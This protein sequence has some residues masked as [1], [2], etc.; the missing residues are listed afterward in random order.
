MAAWRL[1][2]LGGL[3]VI[4]ADDETITHFESRKTAALLAYLALHPERAHPREELAALIWPDAEFEASRN[5]LKQSLA[6]LRKLLGSDVFTADRFSV[7]VVPGVMET[8][9][10]Q[11]ERLV[12]AGR[13]R[14]AAGLWRGELLPGFYDEVLLT[15]R[16]R[17]NALHMKFCS[18][19]ASPLTRLVRLPSPPTRFVGRVAEKAQLAMLLQSERWITVIGPGG[20]GKTRLATEVAR[21]WE[22]GDSAFVALA[23]LERV[24]QVSG[25]IAS[26]LE[27]TLPASKPPLE[28]LFGTLLGRP[29]LLVLDNA[30]HLPVEVLAELC[31]TLLTRLPELRLLVTSRQALCGVGEIRVVLEPL[32]LTEDAPAL[33]L[34]RAQ[35]VRPEFPASEALVHLCALLEGMPLAI[36]L[37][38][39]WAAGLTAAQMQ[40]R[41]E[42]GEF[43]RLLSRRGVGGEEHHFS[44]EAIFHSSYERLTPSQQRLLCGL[45]VFRGGWTLDAAEAVCPT[46]DTLGDLL[47]LCEASLIAPRGAERFAMLESL[48]RFASAL[49]EP[50]DTTALRQRHHAWCLGFAESRNPERDYLVRCDLEL[51]NLRH[52]LEAEH[53]A[54]LL[55]RLLPFMN[56][57]GL[58]AE[59]VVWLERALGESNLSPLLRAELLCQLGA[60]LLVQR[61][62]HT[63]EPLIHE[64][65]ALARAEKSPRVEAMALYQLGRFAEFQQ[66]RA[67]AWDYHQRAL[68]L[69]RGLDDPEALARSCN[70]LSDL[71]V[72]QG[73]LAEALPLLSEAETLARAA[74]REW[75]LGDILYNRAFLAMMSG[76]PSAA[77]I[78][79]SECQA[80]ARALNLRMLLA[81][82]TQSLGCT[83]MEL[84]ETRRAQ[85]ELSEAARLFHALRSKNG[86]SYPLWNLA[87]LYQDSEE[88]DRA[89]VLLAASVR[90]GEELGQ[91]LNPDDQKFVDTLRAGASKTLGV[92]LAE[93]FWQQGRGLPL[94]ELLHRLEN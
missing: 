4:G 38:A 23:P 85:T 71:A 63:A 66:E 61:N 76:D 16:E 79:L 64:A 24:E 60:N 69:R 75:L 39:A 73:R 53:D 33:F 12:R 11:W 81:R 36:E 8:D 90:L 7:R 35:R 19:E 58:I 6:S 21:A 54:S 28:A 43:A 80:L 56:A 84:G 82:A 87:R 30:E 55:L 2:L 46:A 10:A 65:L 49:L 68:E 88:W 91:P 59:Q 42:H 37:C 78:V 25:A 92:V 13:T 20:M 83:A 14:E 62:Q 86:V 27:L 45:T 3:R 34:D 48:R 51:D 74:G 94:E 93:H 47:C 57:R 22:E 26:V 17:L 32:N 15:E 72:Q 40:A 29:T 52:A 77:L 44:V 89:V 70:I 5:R 41:L 50:D 18:E 31:S 67:L 1:E 9:V